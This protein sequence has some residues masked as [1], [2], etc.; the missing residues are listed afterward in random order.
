MNQRLPR[1]IAGLIAG[2]QQVQ[3]QDAAQ[4]Q[5]AQMAMGLQGMLQKRQQE[6]AYKSD[7]AALGPDASTDALAQVVSK[8]NPEKG[9]E[10]RSRA[11]EQK[12]ARE[13]RA[14][15]FAETLALR[16]QTL[17][18][19]REQ[20]L[21]R[22][23]DKA[24]QD[25]INNQFRQSQ[26]DLQRQSQAFQKW[27]T[28]QNIDLKRFMAENRPERPITEFQGKNALYGSRAASS[29]RTLNGLEE[30]ISLVGLAT[31]ESLQSVPVIG[32]ALGAG[33]NVALS[34][35]QQKVE[36]AQRDFVNAVL[37]QESG[38]VISQPEFEN[39]KRQ[40][41]PQPGDKPDVIAQKKANRKM[42]IAGFKRIAG[43]AWA[44]VEEQLKQS[45]IAPA[46]PGG[47]KVIDFGSLK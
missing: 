30:K 11:A 8:Y 1:G 44:D 31:K 3:Q 14:M 43:P 10:I 23:Q 42:A 7:V 46:A 37:R 4:M 21:A 17:D 16:Q 18:Q 28:E 12:D 29:D 34:A 15:Q 9:L 32:G 20:A 33:A 19:Q 27:A 25:A 6:Q 22:A 13:A 5:Q 40:Y 45:D 38:A 36:Q 35:D 24:S 26:L 2:Q 41:F 47:G 39:A